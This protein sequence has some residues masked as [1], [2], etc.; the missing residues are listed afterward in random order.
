LIVEILQ[1][2]ME[3]SSCLGLRGDSRKLDPPDVYG[4]VYFKK[5]SVKSGPRGRRKKEK[6]NLKNKTGWVWARSGLFILL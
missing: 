1:K 6:K 2:T 5:R 4:P 3:H